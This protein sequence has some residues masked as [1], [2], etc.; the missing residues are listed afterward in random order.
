[1]TSHSLQSWATLAWLLAVTPLRAQP[2]GVDA[3]KR[4]YGRGVAQMVM[5]HDLAGAYLTFQ[6][7]AH[8]DSAYKPAI[9]AVGM[10]ASALGH[11]AIAQDYWH[12]FLRLDA[13]SAYAIRVR[14]YLR[15]ASQNIA[16]V[17]PYTRN[18][19]DAAIALKERRDSVAFAH[20]STAIHEDS[21]RWEAPLMLGQL[22][23]R[24][25]QWQAAEESLEIT[26]WLA[27]AS[28]RPQL[29]TM[30]YTIQKMQSATD[31]NVRS[32]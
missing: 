3:A 16:R 7:A 4:D 5:R 8:E 19:R 32:R 15:L 27:P 12:R 11:P 1:V 26:W 17:D 9:Y 31:K 28:L 21:T 29:R 24:K 2:P 22:L 14:G 30:L 23:L 25:H 10:L 6:R 18:I 20:L 13:N